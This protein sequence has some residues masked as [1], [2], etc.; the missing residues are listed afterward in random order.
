MSLMRASEHRARQGSKSAAQRRLTQLSIPFPALASP[1]H[2]SPIANIFL[3]Q[4]RPSTARKKRVYIKIGTVLIRPTGAYP[5]FG[6]E[7][8]SE[9]NGILPINLV[10]RNLSHEFLV[11]KTVE[12]IKKHK[13]INPL[14]DAGFKAF[15]SDEHTLLSFLNGVFQTDERNRIES[16]GKLGRTI[17]WIES[18]CSTAFLY[19]KVNMNGTR[20]ISA[21]KD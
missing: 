17:L 5:A 3:H 8:T 19:Y 18:F 13:Y 11:E 1:T 12:E 9:N 21:K 4:K 7:M 2:P 20:L 14:Y 16:V 15:L 6:K 10:N